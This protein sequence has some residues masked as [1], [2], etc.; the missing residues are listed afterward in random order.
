MSPAVIP[1]PRSHLGPNLGPQQTPGD[2]RAPTPEAEALADLL[3]R[4]GRLLLGCGCPTP[5]I[6]AVIRLTADA[7]GY[8]A[9]VF[10]VP[11]GLWMSLATAT[12][13]PTIRLVRVHHWGTALD[14]LDQLDRVFNAVAAGTCDL[15]EA[16]RRLDLIE[17]APPRF[18]AVWGVAAAGVAS[19]AA[20]VFFGASAGVAALA[21][22]V[23]LVSAAVG[24]LLA[25][26]AHTQL[27]V[28]FVAGLVVG[29]AAWLM[30]AVDPSLPR[31]PLVL[32]GIIV[33]VPGLTLTAGLSEVAQKNLVSGAGRLLDAGMV[34][35]S[36]IFGVGAMAT[37]ELTVNPGHG[38][39]LVEVASGAPLWALALAT[40]VAGG[41]FLV[42]FSVPADASLAALA[43]AFIAWGTAVA[44][45]RLGLTGP[46]GAF[47]GSVAI[48]LFSNLYAR[49]TDRPAQIVLVP[50][51]VLLVPGALS[52]ASIDRVW[53]G[54]VD[55]GL[56]GLVQA[57]VLAAALVIGLLLAN[58]TFPARKVL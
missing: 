8:T 52:F 58:A 10:G 43:A 57:L 26:G 36:L 38:V 1:S 20:A 55:A 53:W 4:L 41:A 30:T 42:V 27:L 29:G 11:T 21:V 15:P 24:R 44:A 12:E 39:Q 5:R 45:G 35:L 37:L 49:R 2:P 14:Q 31:K 25:R 40:L 50:A 17:G 48:G 28:D 54:D 3:A 33:N 23:G 22:V 34:L 51:I 9:E 7:R 19:G 46:A 16:H 18:G 47:L 56:A 6:E 32:A 13:R